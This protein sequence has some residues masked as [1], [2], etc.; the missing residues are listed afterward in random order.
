MTGR[1]LKVDSKW[2]MILQGGCLAHVV[3]KTKECLN[4]VNTMHMPNVISKR[5]RLSSGDAHTRRLNFHE[6]MFEMT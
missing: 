4:H 2:I 1:R 5:V 6:R 3:Y